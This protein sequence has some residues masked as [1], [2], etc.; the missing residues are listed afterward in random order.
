MYFS[1]IQEF[2][3]F[4]YTFSYNNAKKYLSKKINNNVKKYTSKR[5]KKRK[6]EKRK[7]QMF[8]LFT[9]LVAWHFFHLLILIAKLYVFCYE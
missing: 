3:W 6:Q 8:K 5:R 9:W 2:H 4:Y 7:G 1:D